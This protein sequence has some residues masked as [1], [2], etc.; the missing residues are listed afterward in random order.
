MTARWRAVVGWEDRYEVSDTG[1]VR[2]IGHGLMAG[3]LGSKGYRIVTLCRDGRGKTLN[4]HRLVATAF[5]GTRPSG[6]Q[7]NHKDGNPLNNSTENLEYVTAAENSAHAI[8]F[9]LRQVGADHWTRRLCERV[10]RG[11]KNGNAKLT[12]EKIVL[13]REMRATGAPMAL[14]GK[15][16]GVSDVCVSNALKGRTWKHVQ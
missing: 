9:G 1:L 2:R 4:V 10:R 7:V 15:C 14:I 3:G 16:L 11:V 8:R 12:V 6:L 13:A 5:I